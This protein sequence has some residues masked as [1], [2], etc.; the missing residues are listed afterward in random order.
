M[1]ISGKDFRGDV[2]AANSF[3]IATNCTN[4]HECENVLLVGARGGIFFKQ[5]FIES[6]FY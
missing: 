2:V 4:G 6:A 5:F 1:F 3:L